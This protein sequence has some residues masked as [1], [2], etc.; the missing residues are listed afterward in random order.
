VANLFGR[1]CRLSIYNTITGGFG[2]T[3]DQVVTIANLR[4]QFSIRKTLSKEPNDATISVTNAAPTTRGFMQFKGAQVVLEAGYEDSMRVVFTGDI[5]QADHTLEGPNWTSKLTCG[6]GERGFQHARLNRSWRGSTPAGTIVAA[7]I[8][9]MGL[10]VGN[11][12]EVKDALNKSHGYRS[13]YVARG[14]AARELDTVLKAA[15]YE[16]SIQDGQLHISRTDDV[17]TGTVLLSPDSGLIGSPTHG[18]APK[19]GKPP[20]L[21]IKT[22]LMPQLKPGSFVRVESAQ[23]KGD[24]KLI[25]VAHSGDTAGGDWYTESEGVQQ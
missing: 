20:V 23:H 8:E 15:G 6:D 18:S 25:E 12:A 5:R 3:A 14:S 10:G 2:M 1:V 7:A 16:W 9:A 13:G 11:L 17:P 22:L 21:K 19:K 24:F 4:M